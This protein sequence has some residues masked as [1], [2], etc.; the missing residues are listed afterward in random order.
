LT[1]APCLAL[2]DLRALS[3]PG[4]PA[5]DLTTNF[6]DRFD[7][8]STPFFVAM[9]LSPRHAPPSHC[10]SAGWRHCR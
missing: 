1:D 5:H 4:L 7:S 6:S 3:G 2:D 10:G 9:T 8:R